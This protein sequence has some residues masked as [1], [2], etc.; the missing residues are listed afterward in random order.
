MSM[1]IDG[2]CTIGSNGDFSDDARQLLRAMD[3]AC[4]D[5]AVIVPPDRFLVLDNRF[6]NDQVRSLARA[7]SDRLIPAGSVNPWAGVL[8]SRWT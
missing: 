6:G 5:K 1:Y 4:V 2:Y 3:A 8:K 7:H